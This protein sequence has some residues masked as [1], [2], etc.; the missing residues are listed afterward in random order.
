MRRAIAGLV[1]FS[2]FQAGRLFARATRVLNHLAAGTLTIDELRA[3]IE[4]NWDTFASSDAE[5]SAGLARWEQ[6]TLA[7]FVTRD[8]SKIR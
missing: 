2:F 5:V 6:E 4:H 1:A 7:G 3:G 8:D